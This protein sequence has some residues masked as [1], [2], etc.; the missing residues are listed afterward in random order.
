[1][2]S[3]VYSITCKAVVTCFY[4]KGQYLGELEACINRGCLKHTVEREGV[5]SF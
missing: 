4:G 3:I 5:A 2:L 1:M